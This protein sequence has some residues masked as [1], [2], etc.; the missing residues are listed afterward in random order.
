MH[1][2]CVMY[3]RLCWTAGSATCSAASKWSGA[4]WL[5]SDRVKLYVWVAVQAMNR[6]ERAPVSEHCV[7]ALMSN[8][9][10][11]NWA[12]GLHLWVQQMC[13]CPAVRKVPHHQ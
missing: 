12:T 8:S 9:N 11:G 1:G 6:G 4:V 3:I 7:S 2:L 5:V 13:R 10:G